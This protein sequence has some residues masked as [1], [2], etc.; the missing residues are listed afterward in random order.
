MCYSQFFLTRWLTLGIL[1]STVVKAAV[2]TKLVILGISTMQTA[3]K[4]WPG[5]YIQNV[6]LLTLRITIYKLCKPKHLTYNRVNGYLTDKMK[7]LTC[8]WQVIFIRHWISVTLRKYTV[9]SE[10]KSDV[11]FSLSKRCLWHFKDKSSCC[12][13]M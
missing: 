8:R 6:I 10:F 11:D 9:V 5:F 3:I 1:L 4:C 7:V 12:K 13:V 2:V